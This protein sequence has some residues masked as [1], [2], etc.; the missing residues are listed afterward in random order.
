MTPFLQLPRAAFGGEISVLAAHV[1]YVEITVTRV[2]LHLVLGLTSSRTIESPAFEPTD[3]NL[4]IL[5]EYRDSI[6]DDITAKLSS[7]A[8]K[9][10]YAQL[11]ASS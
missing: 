5:R 3:K 2:A 1:S 6:V 4:A 9:V 11:P 10:E 7:S 8:P